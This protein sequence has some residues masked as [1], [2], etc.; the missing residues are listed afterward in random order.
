MTA[1]NEER[2]QADAPSLEPLLRGEELRT[3]LINLSRPSELSKSQ[4]D[5]L[6]EK[7]EPIRLS[8][9]RYRRFEQGLKI[10]GRKGKL[11]RRG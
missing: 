11:P 6:V 9:I 3:A 8:D 1:D 5:Y 7:L 10:A 2:P 4:L